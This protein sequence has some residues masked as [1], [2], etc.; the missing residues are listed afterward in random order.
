[1]ENIGFEF[2]MKY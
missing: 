1:V 2:G